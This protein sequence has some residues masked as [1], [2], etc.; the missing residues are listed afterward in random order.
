M[1]T[2]APLRRRPLAGE[3]ADRLVAEH[4]REDWL[5]PERTLASSLGVSRT[6][7]REAVKLLET[8]GVLEVRHGIGIQM[9]HRPDRAVGSV[10]RRELPKG[11]SGVRQLSEVRLLIEPHVARTAASAASAKDLALLA[12][13]HALFSEATSLDHA[14]AADLEF[15]RLLADIAGNRILAVMLRSVGD[16][17]EKARRLTLRGVG[18]PTAIAQHQKILDAVTARDPA[19]AEAAMRLH[20]SAAAAIAAPRGHETSPTT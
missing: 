7:L 2:R 18:L 12:Q 3:I 8:Q 17:E 10:L 11:L 4:R 15:H 20:V 9:V 14:V 6:A 1:T 16:L 5:P 19:A 13:T